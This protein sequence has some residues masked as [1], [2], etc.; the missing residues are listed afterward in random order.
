MPVTVGLDIGTTSVKAVAADDSGT[1]LARTRVPH[2]IGLPFPGAFEH[3]VDVVWR[4]GV[5]EALRQ[6]AEPLR[7]R[8]DAV[9]VA[10]MVPSLGAVASDGTALGPGLLYGDV[11]GARTERDPSR[12]GDSGELLAFL[13]W[14]AAHAPDAAG[15][16]P[17]QAVANHALCGRG[18]IDSTTAVT[19]HPLFDFVGWDA[20]LASAAGAR[21][22]QLPA[23][24]S[25][26]DPAG[27]VLAGL[28]AEA[29]LVSGGTIDALAE[30]LVAGADEVG[31]VLVI[32]GTTLITWGVIEEW[33]EVD[34]LW[35]VPHTA[36]GSSLVGGPSNAGGLFLDWARRVVGEG[37]D[38]EVDAGDVPVWLPYIRG[39]RTPLHRTD[40]RA[41]LHGLGL[42]H[43]PAHVRRAAYEAAGFVV[44]HH[45][46]RGAAAGLRPKRIVATGGGSRA[47]PWVQALADCT[48]L[49]V[50][51]VAVPEGAALGAAFVARCTA[52]LESSM[53]DARRWASTS[54]T[55]NPREEWIAPCDARYARFLERSL[56]AELE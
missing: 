46:D 22:E 15:Y 16:W 44:R 37:D 1:V 27:E 42:A 28:P 47:E 36:A 56:S 12:P 5:L 33:R 6:V 48:G 52:G 40:L 13:A 34:G 23:V 3:D 38:A 9:A 31:D 54:H 49:P 10:A 19:A 8:I 24:V 17:A 26:T 7:A 21:P 29:A 53:T 43:G 50:D 51:I 14:Q 55:V 30:Q 18:V 4:S 45:L 39:E 35:T 2:S 11:R 25:G 41:S 32:C 20:A